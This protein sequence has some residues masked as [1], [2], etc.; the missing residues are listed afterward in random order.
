MQKV[1]WSLSVIAGS[2]QR[3]CAGGAPLKSTQTASSGQVPGS[4]LNCVQYPPG[5]FG[6]QILSPVGEQ[7]VG[8]RHASPIFALQPPR[9]RTTPSTQRSDGFMKAA[10]IYLT[11]RGSATLESGG[12]GPGDAPGSPRP[13]G[14]STPG[15]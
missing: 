15:P 2:S 4:Q 12:A 10:G 13:T 7:F 11:D 6:S 3:G 14:V 9:I 8:S 5:K 1:R